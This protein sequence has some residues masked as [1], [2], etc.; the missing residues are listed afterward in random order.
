MCFGDVARELLRV[1]LARGDDQVVDRLR[2]LEPEHDRGVAELEV[3]IEQERPAAL[4]LRE[5]RRE[6]RGRDG[7]ARAALRREHGDDPA[8]AGRAALGLEP[9]AGVTGLAE[10]ED[11][12]LGQLRQ[13]QDI[14][15]AFGIECLLEQGRG[16][17]R[18]END[19]R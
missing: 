13:Q 10:R 18:G 15:D 7:L 17:A 14:G 6:V 4:V 11:D 3:E 9:A 16:L 5:R 8:V 19:D 1:E 2:R 12:V